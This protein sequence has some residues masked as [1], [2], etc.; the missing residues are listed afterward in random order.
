MRYIKTILG[1]G[2]LLCAASLPT[3]GATIL[4]EYAFNIDGTVTHNAAPGGVN[5]AGFNTGTGLGSI[6]YT[7]SKLGANYVSF[8]VDHEIDES[9]NTFFNEYGSTSGAG[10][11]AGQSWEIDEPG[12][13]FGNIFSNFGSS[14]LDGVNG[15]PSGSPD[16][17]SMA[18]AWA[19]SLADGQTAT[20]TFNISETAPSGFYLQQTDPDSPASIYFSS[21]LVIEPTGPPGVPDGG[22]TGVS[23]LIGLLGLAGLKRAANRTEK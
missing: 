18:L 20:L 13:S 22:A 10:P 15:V 1:A 23:L 21:S 4:Y 11:A 12:Y 14:A 16:D 19:F 9:P 3:F 7:T 6:T 17:V 8:F 5:L 2:A